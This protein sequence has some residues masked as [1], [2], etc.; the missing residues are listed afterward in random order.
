M[1]GIEIVEFLRSVKNVFDKQLP[2]KNCLYLHG[3]PNAGK[4]YIARSLCVLGRYFCEISN[5]ASF[6]WQMMEFQRI[7]IVEEPCFTPENIEF[8]KKIAEGH[9]TQVQVKGSQ[10][11]FIDRT[12]VIVTTN[13]HIWQYASGEEGALRTRMFV[14]E[15][16]KAL[17]RDLFGKKKLNP[18][19]WLFLMAKYGLFESDER[20]REKE[21]YVEEV[22]EE[23]LQVLEE[24]EK[25]MKEEGEVEESEIEEEVSDCLESEEECGN[26]I[27]QHEIVANHYKMMDEA[28]CQGRQ[29]ELELLEQEKILIGESNLLRESICDQKLCTCD[30][31]EDP[32]DRGTSREST[33][34]GEHKI[35]YVYYEYDKE[36]QAG[37]GS[38]VR[39]YRKERVGGEVT[40]V[41]RDGHGNGREFSE[42]SAEE[43]ASLVDGYSRDSQAEID[44]GECSQRDEG[45]ILFG[46][47]ANQCAVEER[48][49]NKNGEKSETVAVEE[50]SDEECMGRISKKRAN[51]LFSDE[52]DNECSERCEGKRPCFWHRKCSDAENVAS[53]F[54]V[55]AIDFF[56]EAEQV[57]EKF[58]DFKAKFYKFA[59]K[60]AKF[61]DD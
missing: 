9:R 34:W 15:N 28:E 32:Y 51:D 2:K 3:E 50:S 41:E 54:F 37:D 22:E 7:A 8:F 17:D 39:R 16:L 45:I 48:R 30:I 11:V 19:V 60:C 14:F 35:G 44:A 58:G 52:S 56:R 46:K 10:D 20:K 33:L 5:S 57:V 1:N 59:A 42:G 36:S 38:D 21:I 18:K 23:E 29:F 31:N 55:E 24:V 49:E 12:P 40:D 25:R 4:S 6:T 13:N 26:V 27:E 43:Y 61:L 47:D 53:E